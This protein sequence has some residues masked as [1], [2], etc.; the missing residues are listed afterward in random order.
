MTSMPVHT[1]DADSLSEIAIHNFEKVEKSKFVLSPM[2]R[3][4]G[5]T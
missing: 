3:V 1:V 4:D 5:D 2:D